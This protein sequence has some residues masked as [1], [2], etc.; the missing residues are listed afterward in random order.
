MYDFKHNE[1]RKSLLL[2]LLLSVC[3]LLT[4]QRIKVSK[5][6]DKFTKQE[7]VETSMENLYTKHFMG[8][9]ASNMFSCAI[10]KV[11]GN[12]VMVAKILMHD[13]VKYDENSGVIFLLSNDEIVELKSLYTGV[14]GKRLLYGYLFETVYQLSS[15]D[16]DK[17]K[18]AD[19]LSVR[20][21]FLGGSYDCDL[22]KKRQKIV[23]KMLK[24][25]KDEAGRVG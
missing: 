9:G 12:W 22:T 23:A 18:N 16:I 3:E 24:I 1:M 2:L 21:T 17:L 8:L 15:D 19:I 11:D 7:V 13:I 4:A 25:V 5:E 6:Y 10:R 20:I 14:G